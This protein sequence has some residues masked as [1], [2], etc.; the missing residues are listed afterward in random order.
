MPAGQLYDNIAAI[1]AV[2]LIAV[3]A[4]YILPTVNFQNVKTVDEQ[5]LINIAQ[6]LLNSMLLDEGYPKRWGS[7]YPFN[8]GIVQSFG[9]ALSEADKFYVLDP[10]KVQKLVEG[11]PLGYVSYKKIKS[12]L[13]LEDYG[14]CISIKPPF[15]VHVEDKSISL[16][17]LI[18]RVSVSDW[19]GR[20]IAGAN[21]IAT[22][23]YC[24]GLGRG[25]GAVIQ[26]GTKKTVN[27]TNSFGQCEIEQIISES[28]V[29]DAATVIYVSLHGLGTYA[30]VYQD[31]PPQ[32][33]ARINYVNETIILTQNGTPPPRA[34]VEIEKIFIYNYK[35]EI[36][37]EYTGGQLDFITYWTGEGDPPPG[38]KV[39]SKET[40]VKNPALI[41]FIF[42]ATL[43]V[44]GRVPV[45]M[46]GP[47]P[48]WK[49]YR[50]THF[51]SYPSQQATTVVVRR[52]VL[53]SGMTYIAELTLWKEI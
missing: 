52:S 29:I 16:Q 27:T 38:F 15:K 18:F 8:E 53:I 36:V 44:E 33:I 20:P 40:D 46:A 37:W 51:G 41:F 28:N 49:G 23:T 1:T 4:I 34:Q 26:L 9:L 7:Y 5:Q 17:H 50:L 6:N 3:L 35:G 21:V 43:P 45:L 22:T 13:N 11:N 32:N 14:F 25:R 48:L 19:D 12:L 2:G 30:V 47:D 24:T 31:P 42:M 10:D 39:W